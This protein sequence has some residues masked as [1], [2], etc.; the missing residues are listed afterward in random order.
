MP[1][2]FYIFLLIEYVKNNDNLYSSLVDNTSN[3]SISIFPIEI[4]KIFDENHIGLELNISS[5]DY[6]EDDYL[7]F[8]YNFKFYSKEVGT[9]RILL[10]FLSTEAYM[11]YDNFEI[12]C[13]F[14]DNNTNI[15][16]INIIR[17]LKNISI[18]QSNC[19][20]AFD[21]NNKG[22]YNGMY[23]TNIRY[24][25]DSKIIFIIKNDWD[26]ISKMKI[27]LRT[28]IYNLP[29]QEGIIKEK[30]ELT[31]KP[32]YINLS[33][34]E[35]I[36]NEIIL[37]SSL[38][39]L[40][41]YYLNNEKNKYNPS[42]LYKGNIIVLY[43]NKNI[44]NSRYN[45]IKDMILLTSTLD[46]NNNE[47]NNILENYFE[48]KFNLKNS[49]I[50]Y[51]YYYLKDNFPYNNQISLQ[52]IGQ[53][54]KYCF[55]LNY[56]NEDNTNN[57]NINRKELYFELIYGQ[58]KS[59]TVYTELNESSW[60]K[61][62]ENG[63]NFNLNESYYIIN[64]NF[65]NKFFNM[66]CAENINIPSMIHF[67]YSK[68]KNNEFNY[69]ELSL[70]ETYIT[71]I[72]KRNQLHLNITGFTNNNAFDFVIHIF[73]NENIVNI[74]VNFGND[75]KKIIEKNSIEGFKIKIGDDDE[76]TKEIKLYNKGEY[77]C[78]IIIKIGLQINENEDMKDN[79]IYY[80][81]KYNL[82]Y[83]KFMKLFEEYKYTKITFDIELENDSNNLPLFQNNINNTKFFL[84]DNFDSI[85]FPNFDN[86]YFN[87]NNDYKNISS[88]EILNPFILNN[89]FLYNK[90]NNYY[91]IIKPNQVI[92][93]LKLKINYEKYELNEEIK[94]D[95]TSILTLE[96]KNN[97]TG[98]IIPSN[99]NQKS[100]LQMISCEKNKLIEFE[101]YDVF[102]K[103]LFILDSFTSFQYN[104]LAIEDNPIDL[105]I[106]FKEEI[107]ENTSIFLNYFSTTKVSN[108]ALSGEFF[109][110]FNNITNSIHLIK[111]INENDAQFNYTIFLDKNGTL[112]KK[113]ISLCQ[114]ISSHNLN[115]F[116]YYIKNITDKDLIDNEYKLD[117]NSETLKNYKSFDL[118]IFAKEIP[119]GIYFLSNIIK[120]IYREE[121]K[122]IIIKN[123]FQKNNENILYYIGKMN[124][125]NYY[126][127]NTNGIFE[128]LITIHLGNNSDI[129]NINIDCAQINSDFEKDIKN[130]IFE[131]KNRE[132]CK[133]INM[134]SNNNKIINIFIKMVKNLHAS[135]AIRIIN[136]IINCDIG[137]YIDID[138]LSKKKEIIVDEEKENKLININS[139]FCFK[140]YKIYLDDVINNKYNQIGLYSKIYNFISLFINNE[141][142]EKKLIDYGNFII[143]YTN[144]E[145]IMNNYN[146]NKELFVIIGDSTKLILNINDMESE[147]IKLNI[148]G[149]TKKYSNEKSNKIDLIE[150]Y[151]YNDITNINDIFVPLYINKCDNYLDNFII[152]NI[153]QTSNENDNNKKYLKIDFAFGDIPLIEYT[154]ILNKESFNEQINNLM[155]LNLEEKNL[156]LLDNNIYIFKVTCSN[157]LYMNIKGYEINSEEKK[158]KYFIKSGS[159]LNISLNYQEEININF[160]ELRNSNLT[161]IELSNEQK[162]FEVTIE[163][164]NSEIVDLNS[165]NRILILELDKYIYNN[166]KIKANKESGYIQILT[167]INNNELF[168]EG[169]N[170][171]LTYNN[172]ELYIYSHKIEPNNDLIKINIPIINRDKSKYISV[173]YYL[174]QIIIKNKNI[175]NCFIISENSLENITI[176]NPYNIYEVNDKIYNIS[177]VYIIFYKNGNNNDN[178][179]E[180]REVI[181]EEEGK[182]GNNNNNE[183]DRE[184]FST[185]VGRLVLIIFIVAIFVTVILFLFFYLRKL[186]RKRKE[187]KYQTSIS[188]DNELLHSINNNIY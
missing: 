34:F 159:I 178:K 73:N 171:Y 69:I 157:Y 108:E 44:I 133:I 71:N 59:I 57:D 53:N 122:A 153:K 180:L 160:N 99:V 85:I 143:I 165:N 101:I 54:K 12:K 15:S 75:T 152:F 65:K 21:I 78:S 35:S 161:K 151:S 49:D 187:M 95:S 37:Y 121:K 19:I 116:A 42:L 1:I 58:I 87:S 126:K 26:I 50:N 137:I 80:N 32:Y 117:F 167:N 129:N 188:N 62:I 181:I 6:I 136:E 183:E 83:F 24:D 141:Y 168:K 16:D 56:Q 72:Q 169:N 130:A 114:I 52:M 25:I 30:E 88:F 100:Y 74:E 139:P 119:T 31:L 39:D 174:S 68:L 79:N 96:G 106:Y 48:I 132:I 11:N 70:G 112:S 150:Y 94:I 90:N 142:N 23:R 76:G 20:G 179:L 66:I 84:M 144:N 55:I 98:I 176:R 89:K 46:N 107:N 124:S 13:L 47:D 36:A 146:Q 145:Y 148:I 149:L 140:Y 173:C 125:I 162:N 82:Y 110:E 156:I 63:Q 10:E 5:L 7:F 38:N 154:N 60:D 86:F 115:E 163:F 103:N 81:L 172:K 102:Y 105:N 14:V 29:F 28:N 127:I 51:N 9:F 147:P 184:N 170:N 91:L 182:K 64:N 41:L 138:N 175:Q 118:L 77:N 111:P 185:K 17:Y 155:K 33:D 22:K 134:K 135:L 61:L 4:N 123:I 104:Y 93:N 177:N 109:I 3:H 131:Q 164:E 166:I 128:G 92:N 45:N 67:Y 186:H 120:N 18:E 97:K 158:K 8:Y 113:N 2:Y 40:Y 43:T 27:Y